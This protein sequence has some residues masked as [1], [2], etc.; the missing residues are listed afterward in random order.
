M[1]QTE[2]CTR[3]TYS[4]QDDVVVTGRN[5]DWDKDDDLKVHIMPK[6]VQRSSAAQNPVSWT[7]KYGSVVA[8]SFHGKVANSG[9]N[10][11]GLQADLLYL[12]EATYGEASSREKSLEAKNFI[13]YVLDNYETVSELEKS[14]KNK[15]LHLIS[16]DPVAGLH[17]M[18]TDKNGENIIIEIKDG[19][20]KLYPKAGNV[21]MTNDPDY[22]SMTKIYDYYKE[23]DLSR[24]MPGS[25][26]SVDRFMRAAGWLEQLSK[27][28]MENFINLVPG[29]DFAMQATMS[30]LSV[31]RNVSTPFAISVERNPENSTTIWREVSDLKNRIMMFDL[32]GSPSIVW[33]DLKQIDF[34]Q[35]ESVLSLSDGQ[36]K[37]GDITDQFIKIEQERK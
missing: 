16:H 24:N 20:L 3:I 36:I 34:N 1:P 31:M 27:D 9:M 30:V 13:Q 15:P 26:H 32:A 21:V 19:K 10:E 14:L 2:A 7:A 4:A 6:K 35:G 37:H 33:I 11:E 25:P 22:E 5:M 23:K 28:K 17:Y 8:Y 18:V 12:G 29:K